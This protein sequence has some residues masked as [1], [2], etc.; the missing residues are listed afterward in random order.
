MENFLLS[1][2]EDFLLKDIIRSLF[3]IESSP[4]SKQV[5]DLLKS[6]ERMSKLGGM[7]NEKQSLE[8]F[9]QGK[10]NLFSLSHC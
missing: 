3:V 7:K 9:A 2:S 1:F 5:L 6:C 4:A 10:K 8:E